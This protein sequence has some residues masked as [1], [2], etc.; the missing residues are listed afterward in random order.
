MDLDSLQNNN[1]EICLL[2][3]ESRGLWVELHSTKIPMNELTGI[4]M[5]AFDW[6][7]KQRDTSEGI[8]GT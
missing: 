8:K 2:K 7:Q 1:P 3:D 4:S 5:G 6:L